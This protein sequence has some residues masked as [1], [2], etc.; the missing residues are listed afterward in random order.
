MTE[1]KRTWD[2]VRD[3]YHRFWKLIARAAVAAGFGYAA[4]D[5]LRAADFRMAL[6]GLL[7]LLLLG[8]WQY[9]DWIIKNRDVNIGKEL[10]S[11]TKPSEQPSPAADRSDIRPGVDA[12]RGAVRD[13]FI[14]LGNQHYARARRDE[15]PI[16][17]PSDNVWLWAMAYEHYAA[18]NRIQRSILTAFRCMECI[19]HMD[20]GKLDQLLL[21]Y[22]EQALWHVDGPREE[23]ENRQRFA[24]WVRA[25]RRLLAESGFASTLRSN[26]KKANL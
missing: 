5:G 24:E 17:M 26:L 12:L 2:R 23:V 10:L 11:I 22:F 18:A 8:F 21:Q 7:G 3:A 16:P 13:S 14:Y 19:A 6:L 4:W 15:P 20:G 1:K 9:V 25:R